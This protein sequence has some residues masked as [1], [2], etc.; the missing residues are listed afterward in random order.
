MQEFDHILL[1][2]IG[3]SARTGREIREALCRQQG[4]D[5]VS[6]VRIYTTLPK[7]EV[8]GWLVRA[9]CSGRARQWSLSGVGDHQLAR[10][11]R[12]PGGAPHPCRTS[13]LLAVLACFP[14][15]HGDTAFLLRR[16]LARLEKSARSGSAASGAL[17]RREDL[18]RDCAREVAQEALRSAQGSRYR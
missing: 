6:A 10:W 7:L 1:S 11:L 14:V 18:R 17:R 2:C 5:E 9:G 15:A 13:E 16:E 8:R 3:A 12:C 4:I